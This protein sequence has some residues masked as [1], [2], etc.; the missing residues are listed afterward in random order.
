MDMDLTVKTVCVNEHQ[1]FN[2]P[3]FTDELLE[4]DPEIKDAG[5]CKVRVRW[6]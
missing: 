2:M 4:T 6:P 5:V 1:L 3:L